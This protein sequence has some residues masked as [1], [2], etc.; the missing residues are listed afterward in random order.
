MSCI[1]AAALMAAIA[2]SYPSYPASSFSSSGEAVE[3]VLVATEN[4]I[5]RG[6][7]PGSG[8]HQRKSRHW[9]LFEEALRSKQMYP[10]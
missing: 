5:G 3:E 9:Y 1:V 4:L 8:I 2:S 10:I 6:R 7:D